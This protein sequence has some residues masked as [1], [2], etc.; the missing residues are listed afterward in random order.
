MTSFLLIKRAK[1]LIKET[2]KIQLYYQ[3]RKILVINV[4]FLS[5]LL[6]RKSDD[7]EMSNN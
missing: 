7:K 1:Q 4:C 6:I 5:H 2:R 3:E